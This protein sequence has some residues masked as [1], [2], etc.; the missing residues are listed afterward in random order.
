MI[1]TVVSTPEQ[2]A[3]ALVLCEQTL[4]SLRDMLRRLELPATALDVAS[5]VFGNHLGGIVSDDWVKKDNERQKIILEIERAQVD[6]SASNMQQQMASMG[7]FP[8]PR[9]RMSAAEYT[10]LGVGAHVYPSYDHMSDAELAL[11]LEKVRKR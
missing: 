6:A 3:R 4:L 2:E 10:P 5:K 1:D 11:E 9:P 8:S 7:A